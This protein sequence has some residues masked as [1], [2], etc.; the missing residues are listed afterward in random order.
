VIHTNKADV[1]Q[2]SLNQN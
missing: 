1:I 2:V